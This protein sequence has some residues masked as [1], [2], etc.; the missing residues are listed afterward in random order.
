MC[1]C[2]LSALLAA[3]HHECH[4]KYQHVC[5]L[6]D[7]VFKQKLGALQASGL[8]IGSWD[9]RYPSVLPLLPA[10]EAIPRDQGSFQESRV[11]PP[12]ALL[13]PCSNNQKQKMKSSKSHHCGSTGLWK[14]CNVRFHTLH[15]QTG[16]LPAAAGTFLKEDSQC[17]ASCES[18]S[19]AAQ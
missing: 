8:L 5:Y 17:R 7:L 2:G 18:P 13:L 11:W 6:G 14:D 12:P 16:L 1:L 9:P 15:H 3:G 4:S 10:S 19:F